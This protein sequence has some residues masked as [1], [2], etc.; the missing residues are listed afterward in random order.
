MDGGFVSNCDHM[1]SNGSITGWGLET[2]NNESVAISKVTF[3]K[4]DFPIV[5][6]SPYE[7]ETAQRLPSWARKPFFLQSS[8]RSAKLP[9]I[10]LVHVGKTAGSTIACLLGFEYDCGETHRIQGDVLPLATKHLIHND[11]I[12]CARDTTDYYLFTLRDPLERMKS[13]FR[14]ERPIQSFD[15]NYATKKQLF[16]D[17]PF[18]TL[19]DLA[20][21]GL[22][23]NSRLTASVM[24]GPGRPSQVAS[25]MPIITTTIMAIS[26]ILCHGRH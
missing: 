25:G 11:I 6:P 15:K 18:A 1:E 10:C 13:W 23:Q 14:D 8:D 17:C 21:L 5:E 7:E 16:V 20:V 12:D 2:Q 26:G 19:N 24:S 9:S 22:G 3:R 4:E